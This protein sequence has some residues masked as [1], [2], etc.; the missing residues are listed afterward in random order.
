MRRRT[1]N[2]ILQSASAEC[3]VACVTMILQFFGRKIDLQSLRLRYDVTLRGSSLRDLLVMLQSHGVKA[4][5]MRVGLPKLPEI[6][7]P[8]I[9]HWNFD[10]FVILEK[11]SSA[12]MTI[13]DPAIGRRTV[14]REIFDAAYTGIL[15]EV[16]DTEGPAEI[17]DSPVRPLKLRDMLPALQEV[18]GPVAQLLLTTLALNVAA[19]AI[20]L[21]LT[22]LLGKVV[23]SG[24]M[25]MLW[26]AGGSFL[27]LVLLQGGTRL[28]RGLALV[29]LKR[30][31]SDGLTSVVFDR[32]IWL[33]CSV[34]ERRSAGTIATNYRSIF[35][36]S[37]LLSEELLAA[38]V[39]SFSAIAIVVILFWFDRTIG[40]AT[41]IF[42]GGY[43]VV[44]AVAA[45]RTKELLRESLSRE[46]REGGFFVESITRLPT[47]RVFQ[48]ES[49][50]S[51]AFHN[52][53]MEL[54]DSRQRHA[55]FVNVQRAIGETILQIG[56]V[57]VL[58]FA[59]YRAINGIVGI[60]LLATI[61]V[62]LGLATSRVRDV[63]ARFGQMDSID[64]HV[65]RI[66]DIVSNQSDRHLRAH[67]PLPFAVGDVGC[68]D[69]RF[70]YGRSG[71]WV[72][73]GVGFVA[74]AGQWTTI[75]GASGQ[76]KSTL[77]KILA[78]L[79]EPS[80]GTIQN[81][82]V[83]LT[84]QQIWSLRDRMAVVLQNDGLFAGSIRDNITLFD[85]TA[86]EERMEHCAML[87]EIAKDVATMP[88]R[89]DSIVGE[90]GGGLSAG[91]LQRIMLARALY[92]DPEILLLDEF[93]ANLDEPSE[94]AIIRNLRSLG[95]TII[96]IAHRPQVIAAADKAY[97]LEEGKLVP[98]TQPVVV[99]GDAPD[100]V[101]NG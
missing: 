70:R 14:N 28:T 57:I 12:K 15:L 20:P 7:L 34:V 56:W 45:R 1:L 49:W 78:G 96:A 46:A 81:D 41:L 9:I 3:G 99:R 64:V 33:N 83:D 30:R 19:I 74:P 80:A 18:R 89:Y 82:G 11:F 27:L 91:Q 4:R 59:G 43:L 39:D 88:M 72:V 76:G 60:P 47:L 95:K 94:A 24:S 90:Q 62:W 63:A 53:H 25:R 52:V 65:D 54:E 55:E 75:V 42:L 5:P 73:D 66:A 36:L 10:H 92:R 21:F 58:M 87:A 13:V 97:F 85:F 6:T 86:D 16:I 38:F 23:P 67:G 84:Q 37:D 31:I 2:P 22:A 77:V 40:T 68:R 17:V 48:A 29:E 71:P 98:V 26:F 51:T 100:L 35:A 93:T 79:I 32:L 8:C 44:S 69:L 50:R 61:V 101:V